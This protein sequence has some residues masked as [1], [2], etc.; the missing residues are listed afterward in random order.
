MNNE[1]LTQ[2]DKELHLLIHK[3]MPE[4]DER[5]IDFVYRCEREPYFKLFDELVNFIDELVAGY[6]K[7]R[8]RLGE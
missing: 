2:L 4:N 3:Y 1:N 7:V 6:A 5:Y 8:T